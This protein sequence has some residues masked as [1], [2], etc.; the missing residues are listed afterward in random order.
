LGFEV[1]NGGRYDGLPQPSAKICR[2]SVSLSASIG[3]SRSQ[4]LALAIV[5]ARHR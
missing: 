1:A 4:L 5:M 2:A 3:W